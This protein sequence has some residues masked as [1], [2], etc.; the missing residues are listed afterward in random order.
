[1]AGDDGNLTCSGGHVDITPL[2]PMSLAGYRS[3]FGVFGSIADTLEAN[4]IVLR[5]GDRTLIFAQLDVMSVGTEVRRR[6]LDRLG[7]RIREEELLLIASHTHSA[8]NVDCRLPDLGRIDHGY[9][10]SVADKTAGLIEEIISGEGR[11][12]RIRYGEGKASHSMNRRA[13]CWA[14]FRGFPP[15][16]KVMAWHPNPYGE[17][18]ETVRSFVISGEPPI[19][20]PI[21]VLWNYACHP[22]GFPDYLAVSADY[23]GVVRRH[24]RKRMGNDLPVIFLPGFA[25][26]VRPNKIDLLP[27]SLY[28]FAHRLVNGPVWGRFD[29]GSWNEWAGSLADV[30]T[31]STDEA[32]KLVM[33]C[34]IAHRHFHPI[35]EIMDGVVDDRILTYHLVRLSRSFLFI[36]ISAEPVVEYASSLRDAFPEETVIPVGYIDGVIGYLPTSNMLDEGGLEVVSPGYSLEHVRFNGMISEKILSI[37]RSCYKEIAGDEQ[38]C[39]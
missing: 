19:P 18:D 4:V 34:F 31:A 22:V 20:E 17:K 2:S 14:P 36:A 6:I 7:E 30:V 9:M 27:K 29:A 37:I 8:P 26:N 28:Y 24:L 25:G 35:K 5:Q 38:V 23:P 11:P 33:P 1:M 10:E 16:R 21:G 13:W 15:I 12:A 32:K 39:R 3:R